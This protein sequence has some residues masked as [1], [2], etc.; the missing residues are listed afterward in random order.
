MNYY[1]ISIQTLQYNIVH[2]ISS[3]MITSSITY[4]KPEIIDVHMVIAHAMKAIYLD[5]CRVI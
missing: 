1:N 3:K 4:C 2:I 5:T